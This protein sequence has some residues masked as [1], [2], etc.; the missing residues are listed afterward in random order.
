MNKF[1]IN[2]LLLTI[3]IVL[4]SLPTIIPAQQ[5]TDHGVY[6]LSGNVGVSYTNQNYPGWKEKDLDL[7]LSPG[8]SC[9]V[10]DNLELGLQL[11]YSFNYFTMK[12]S[13][14]DNPNIERSGWYYTLYMSPTFRYYFPM[15]KLLPFVGAKISFYSDEH[16]KFFKSLKSGLSTI[17]CGLDF[18]I[19]KNIALEPSIN[20]DFHFY[21][22][23]GSF[24]KISLGAGINYF[25]L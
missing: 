3:L 12:L 18:F 19:S 13:G 25:I 6:R 24:N 2:T 20:Y 5:P 9:F 8:Y 23:G 1:K 10:V 14:H 15:E 11:S 4:F 21:K 17:S 7:T 22:N 16:M